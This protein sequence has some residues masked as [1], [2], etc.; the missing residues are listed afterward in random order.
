M[1]SLLGKLLSDG[2]FTK[3]LYFQSVFCKSQ[4]QP[5][6][7]AYAENKYVTVFT[8]IALMGIS[9]AAVLSNKAYAATFSQNSQNASQNV[10]SEQTN[11]KTKRI[12]TLSP[13]LTELVYAVG[14]GDSLIAVSDY[15]DY[16]EQA[17]S[18]PSVAGYQGA[19]IAEIMRLQP[20]HILVW[21]GGNKDA[22]IQKLVLLGFNIFESRI[23]SLQN[24]VSEIKQ[25]G[26]FLGSQKNAN[27]LADNIKA[28]LALLKK[29]YLGKSR[30]VVYY[31]SAQPFM[32]LG[33]DPWLND[34]LQT[35]GLNNLYKDSLG[36]YPQLQMADVVRK[37][38]EVMIVA[39]KYSR[40][41]LASFWAPH[42]SVFNPTLVIANPDALHR[43]T[44]RSVNEIIQVCARAYN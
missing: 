20:T 30:S 12:I 5:V 39:G 28:K 9:A 2:F 37:K 31:L 19:N 18:L 40:A 17:K 26:L 33:S 16:P 24:L 27:T 43:F 1:D 13:H 25:I 15:S 7:S 21:R 32:G 36:A 10:S 14:F 29:D 42:Q 3:P 34:L 23:V 35:C 11:N 8:L 22:D 41:Q 6:P 44:S 38:P 4:T